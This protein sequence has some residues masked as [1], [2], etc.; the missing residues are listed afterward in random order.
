M[1]SPD[2]VLS[3]VGQTVTLLEQGGLLAAV[4]LLCCI[5]AF[6][7]WALYKAR[8]DQM[9]DYGVFGAKLVQA[10]R[11]HRE[12]AVSIVVLAKGLLELTSAKG[13]RDAA[14]NARKRE[15][16]GSSGDSE[17]AANGLDC[18]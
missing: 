8:N 16:G 17:G 9:R 10:E 13:L 1:L 5:I 12:T 15:G 6:L 2:T 14:R 4:V 18:A 3:G 7:M 11:E